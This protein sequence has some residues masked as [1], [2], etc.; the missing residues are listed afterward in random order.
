MFTC[1]LLL[2]F[3]GTGVGR[4]DSEEEKPGGLQE[5]GMGQV[6]RN[7]FLSLFIFFFLQIE[8]FS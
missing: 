6:S 4:M 5:K 7:S 2:S 1:Y 8:T 3:V